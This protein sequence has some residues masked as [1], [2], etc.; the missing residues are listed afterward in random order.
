MRDYLMALRE[1]VTSAIKAGTSLERLIKAG[2][3]L[4]GFGDSGPLNEHVLTAAFEEF[5]P[6]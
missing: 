4:E 1:H 3:V 6:K 2:G 5:A